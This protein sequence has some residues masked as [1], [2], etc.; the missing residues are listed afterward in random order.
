M[1]VIR[2][3][4]P[5]DLDDLH[6]LAKQTFF[7]NLPPDRDIISQK[8]EQSTRSFDALVRTR[9][10][11][12]KAGPSGPAAHPGRHPPARTRT[13]SAHSSDS[14][15]RN[16]TNV[17]DLFLF[18]LENTQ[19]RA[20]IGTSQVIARMGGP[21]HTRFFMTLDR[22]SCT[23]R[24][25]GLGWNHLVGRMGGDQSGPTEIGGIILN[26]AFRGHP[27]HLGRLLSFVRFHFIGL[28]RRTFA[29]NIVAEMLG[30]ITRTGYNPF[31]EKFTRH[32]ITRPFA[33]VYRFSQTSREFMDTLM[34][35]GDV[36]LSILDPE[37]ANA[38]G[39]VGS[40]TLPARRILERLGFEY[41][42]RIDPMDGG[43]HLEARTDKISLVKN[44]RRVA[45][46]SGA[47]KR[48]G[49]ARTGAP[50]FIASTLDSNGGFRAV[51]VA[52]Q[53]ASARPL[54]PHDALDLLAED[55]VLVRGITPLA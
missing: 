34:P 10:G 29:D 44:T 43:P 23:S 17:G 21:G 33:D 1:F 14:G 27:L 12:K 30:P 15:L 54:I 45:A 22:V 7:I 40:D 24:S 11:K 28:H 16:L 31:Y 20:V 2:Q 13:S 8:I 46:F 50:R 6:A 49:R 52:G 36:F 42:H 26:H 41:F 55:A 48:A 25:L 38:A 4:M 35:K 39:E 19:T 9:H 32:F 53:P 51:E 3:A 47:P 18:V 5:Q 37:V